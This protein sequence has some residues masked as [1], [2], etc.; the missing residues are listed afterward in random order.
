VLHPQSYADAR[1]VGEAFRDG[2]TT[3]INLTAC[4]SEDARRIVDFASGLKF[5][6]H[7]TFER[8]DT[9]V[10]LL[11][12]ENSEIISDGVSTSTTTDFYSHN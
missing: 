9:K 5:A 4:T 3:L 7:G 6:L 11:S 2:M 10:F 8:V 1:S 12:H